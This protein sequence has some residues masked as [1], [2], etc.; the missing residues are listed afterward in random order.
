MRSNDRR[1]ASLTTLFAAIKKVLENSTHVRNLS[2]E[3]TDAQPSPSS[4]QST[5]CARRLPLM[6]FVRALTAYR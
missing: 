1:T 6:K 2:V 4:G 3:E 5:G